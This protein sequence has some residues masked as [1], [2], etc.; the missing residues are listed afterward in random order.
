MSRTKY[1]CP[2]RSGKEA[3]HRL[4]QVM[5]R[6]LMI[7][8]VL[9][10]LLAAGGASA[11]SFQPATWIVPTGRVLGMDVG[12][13]GNIYVG[14]QGW[15]DGADWPGRVTPVNS[16]AIAFL[17]SFN[18][19]GEFR[20]SRPGFNLDGLTVGSRRDIM[21]VHEIVAHGNRL[22]TNEG[23]VFSI[24]TVITGDWEQERRRDDG[25]LLPGR[26]LACH[27]VFW[28]AGFDGAEYRPV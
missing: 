26:R 13:E 9:L 23:L 6:T 27:A 8:A 16:L 24:N 1:H 4:I 7:K 3:M 22:Y 17:A 14:G 15:H 2:Y 25:G 12:P 5:K 21:D 11:Q 20:W 28:P 18:A 10:T 19:D